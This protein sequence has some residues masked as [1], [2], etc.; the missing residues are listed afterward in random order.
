MNEQAKP[1]LIETNR[2][3]PL[4]DVLAAAGLGALVLTGAF[5]EP[6]LPPFRGE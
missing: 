5:G 2:G 1:I 4:S 3:V 6:K